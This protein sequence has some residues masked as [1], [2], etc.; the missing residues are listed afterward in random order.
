[1]NNFLRLREKRAKSDRIDEVAVGPALE[2]YRGIR[3][4]LLLYTEIHKGENVGPRQVSTGAIGGGGTRVLLCN[5]PLAGH[6][7][8]LEII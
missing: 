3:V 6:Y 1:V 7:S 5:S 4:R 8:C 2:K